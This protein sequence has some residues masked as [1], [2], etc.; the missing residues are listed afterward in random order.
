MQ[1][2]LF[3]H[4]SIWTMLFVPCRWLCIAFGVKANVFIIAYCLYHVPCLVISLILPLLPV[5]CSLFANLWAPCS[6]HAQH[7]I[8]CC[9]LHRDITCHLF[10]QKFLPQWGLL[11]S[12]L[13][14]C[15]FFLI[16]LKY[17]WFTVWCRF[18]LCINM[19]RLTCLFFFIFVSVAESQVHVPDAQWGQTILK[20][21]NLEQRLVYYRAMQGDG[22][23][24]P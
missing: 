7:C 23:F 1:I 14:F 15:L 17:S 4:G 24:M 18:L 10:F 12:L 20:Q 8:T 13:K 6:P 2:L 22:S 11:G 5:C 21:W 9:T 3:V 19:C 16:L